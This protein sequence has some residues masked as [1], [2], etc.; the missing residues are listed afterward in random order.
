MKRFDCV[1]AVIATAI[2]YLVLILLAFCGGGVGCA[3]SHP[4]VTP[5]SLTAPPLTTTTPVQLQVV[6]ASL[7]AIIV[8]SIVALGVAIGLFF[9]LPTH[10]LSFAI[11][12]I[13]GGVEAS[14]LVARVS[15]WFV[16]WLALLLALAAVGV[17]IYEVWKNRAAIEAAI[18]FPA[19]EADAKAVATK[20]ESVVS[21]TATKVETVAKDAEA[22]VVTAFHPA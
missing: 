2:V 18:D 15:L 16:P 14:A 7:N 3:A 10:N 21:T 19:V 4:T 12:A 11:A 13:A 17:F 5:A 1:N 20:V 22:K 6:A 8:I 9:V